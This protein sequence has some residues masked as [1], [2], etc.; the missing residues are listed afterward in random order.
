MT[1]EQLVDAL[2]RDNLFM[3]KVTRWE[4]LPARGAQYADFPSNFDPRLKDALAR[5]GVH[6]LYTHQAHSFEA[7]KSGKDVVVV[8]PTASGKT[9]CYNLP[10]L[11]EILKDPDSRACISFPPKPCPLTRWQS[12][13]N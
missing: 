5:H 13:M 8:T 7:I 4:T 11:S 10:V 12:C 9:L 2:K 6:Q 1:V 3:E